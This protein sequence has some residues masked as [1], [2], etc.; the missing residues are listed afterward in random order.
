MKKLNKKLRKYFYVETISVRVKADAYKANFI[1]WYANFITIP[2]FGKR[3]TFIIGLNFHLCEDIT[4]AN[5][6]MDLQK[7]LYKTALIKKHR[8]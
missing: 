1:V 8:A 4:A 7:L 3:F 2:M 6:F 5:E